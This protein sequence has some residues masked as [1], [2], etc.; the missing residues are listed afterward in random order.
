METYSTLSVDQQQTGRK[1]NNFLEYYKTVLDK[2]SFDYDLF[3][4]EYR[5][6][7]KVLTPDETTALNGWIES[8][9]PVTEIYA[10]SASCA[11]HVKKKFS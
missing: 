4:K 5:K 9:R 2:V 6:A 8:R 11:D 3:A 1:P 10:D 7:V